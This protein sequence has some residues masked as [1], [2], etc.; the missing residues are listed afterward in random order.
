[1]L[2][3]SKILLSFFLACRLGLPIIESGGDKKKEEVCF[4]R[5]KG[6]YLMPFTIGGEWVAKEKP[7]PPKKPVKVVLEKKKN[8]VMTVVYNLP[9]DASEIAEIASSLKKKLGCGG[10]AKEGKIVIQGSKVAE[11]QGF[12]RE[13]GIK[14]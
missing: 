4:L 10:S 5:E 8:V 2:F 14:V 12:L 3:R 6:A 7:L 11:V 13:K 9:M 1:M